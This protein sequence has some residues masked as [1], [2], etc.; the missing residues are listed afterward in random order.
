MRQQDAS[1]DEEYSRANGCKTYQDDASQVS[2]I[3]IV[4]L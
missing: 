2:M 1:L 3:N 4:G